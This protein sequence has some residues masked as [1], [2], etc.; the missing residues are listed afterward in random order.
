VDGGGW[1]RIAGAAV[2]WI[3]RDLDRVHAA[4]VDA[5][6]GR[7][8]TDRHGCAEPRRV[9]PAAPESHRPARRLPR[10]GGAHPSD[11]AGGA[12]RL[13][14]RRRPGRHRRALPPG[15]GCRPTPDPVV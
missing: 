4:W 6:A 8:P 12:R 2:D 7:P 9:G 15:W 3:Y 1:L 11:R 5:R 13:R 14:R 10:P